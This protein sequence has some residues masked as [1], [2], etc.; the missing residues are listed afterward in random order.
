MKTTFILNC[1][2]LLIPVNALA[3]PGHDAGTIGVTV[4]LLGFALLTGIGLFFILARLYRRRKAV[5][6]DD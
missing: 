6:A 4:Q 3:H 2:M 1:L 5:R